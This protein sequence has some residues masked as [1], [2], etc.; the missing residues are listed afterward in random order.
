M[1]NKWSNSYRI[2]SHGEWITLSGAF[3]REQGF[4][5][6]EKTDVISVGIDKCGGKRRADFCDVL[7][8]YLS[9]KGVKSICS[10][11]K[12]NCL[13]LVGGKHLVND[14]YSGF[15]PRYVSSTDLQGTSSFLDEFA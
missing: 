2:H 6:N 9:I 10:I 3:L 14:M 15:T 8:S 12:K 4:T 5:I 1:V 7:E 11:N 13:R